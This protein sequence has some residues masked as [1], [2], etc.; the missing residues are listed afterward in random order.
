MIGRFDIGGLQW[1]KFGKLKFGGIKY[2]RLKYRDEW[3]S[4]SKLCDYND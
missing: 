3:L 1:L 4:D 2:G